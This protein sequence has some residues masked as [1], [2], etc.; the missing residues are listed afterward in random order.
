[1]TGDQRPLA[2]LPRYTPEH[3]SRRAVAAAARQWSGK[4]LLD[5]CLPGYASEL[6]CVIGHGVSADRAQ[7]AS[8]SNPYGFCIEWLRIPAGNKVGWY[9]LAKKQ[10]R[11][12]LG[13]G[14]P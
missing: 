5:S 1:M 14:L 6:A 8:I 10:S 11:S 12:R 7:T 4:A 9:Q 13:A 2:T 3:I